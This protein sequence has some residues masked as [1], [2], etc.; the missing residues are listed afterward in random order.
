M[1]VE[2]I[3]RAGQSPTAQRGEANWYPKQLPALDARELI[4]VLRRRKWTMIICVL[5]ITGFTA[6][7]LSTITPQYETGTSIMLDERQPQL[8]DLESIVTGLPPG[9]ETMQS[10]V[11]VILSRDFADRLIRKLKL[12]EVPE[13]NRNL[14]EASG[15]ERFTSRVGAFIQRLMPQTVEPEPAPTRPVEVQFD[16]ERIRIINILL[17]KI[18]VEPRQGTW[19]IDITTRSESADLA[20]RLANT[21]GDL[22]LVDQLEAKYDATKRT[23]EWL[24]QRMSALRAD[25]EQAE[26]AVERFRASAGLLQGGGNVTLAQQQISDVN[27]QL[28][29]AR[30]NRAAVEARL[31]QAEKLLRSPEGASSASEVLQSPRIQNL[32][33][34]QT[35]VLRKIAE[36]SSS[37]GENFPALISARAEERDLRAA[38]TAEIAKVV[39]GLRNDTAVAR[40]QEQSLQQ[41]LDDL[42]GK[43]AGLNAKDAELRVLEREAE[44]SRTLYEAFMSKFK[45]TQD[46]DK[47]QQSDARIIS[48]ADVPLSPTVPNKPMV[49][50]LAAVLSLFVGLLVVGMR[51]LFDRGLR[52]T[53]EVYRYFDLPC[54]GLVPAISRLRLAGKGA[55]NY[56]VKKPGSAYAEAVRSLRTTL[57]LSDADAKPRVV[58]VTSARPNEGKTAI[59]ISMARTNAM[60]GRRSI[61]V[62][63]DLRKPEIH[64]RLQART[65]TGVIDY[66]AEQATLADV[67][68]KD[69]ATALE[70]I[71]AGRRT[72]NF[73]ELLR[74]N[75]LEGLLA[76]LARQYELIILDVPP[77]LAVADARIISRLA[78]KTVFIVRWGETSREVVRLALQ[79]LADA[80]VDVAGIAISMVDVRRNAQYGFGDSEAFTGAYKRY[81]SG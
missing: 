46:Q 50:A 10:Q 58:A 16:D 78:D 19:V 8:A 68:Q 76:E 49:I 56:V 27:T 66:L 29:A 2:Q 77:V 73:A 1:T 69:E 7:V 32:V 34:Q 70:Y 59:A 67:I 38:L 24:T 80:G 3:D 13:F 55:E 57:L 15:W 18:T 20:A 6:A 43:V 71:A 11:A 14:R 45:E 40:A 22:Y 5:L 79:Q 31:Q 23:A 33:A 42:E 64:Q 47:I 52:S 74:S 35:E 53:E 28:V 48:R 30:I 12:Y 75:R 26:G 41:S 54:L 39:D 62:D 81:Y 61:L 37:V 21:I 36:L 17:S 4:G 65:E 72:A 25:L 9:S 44:T 51:E 63:L 60:G